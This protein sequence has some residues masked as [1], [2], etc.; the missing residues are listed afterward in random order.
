MLRW[1][2]YVFAAVLIALSAAVLYVANADLKGL[3]DEVESV[4][5]RSLGRELRIDGGFSL[6]LGRTV[7]IR[8]ADV[9][10]ENAPWADRSDMLEAGHV[11][12]DLELWSMFRGPI[13]VKNIEIHDAVF[14]LQEDAH[15]RHN[16]DPVGPGDDAERQTSNA[17]DSLSAIDRLAFRNTRI[18]I[19][20]P[21]L[22]DETQ[23]VVDAAEYGLRDSYVHVDVAARINNVPLR[24]DMDIGP[25][26][27]LATLR[28]LA[29]RGDA[30]LGEITASM[31][32]DIIDLG[33]MA[34]SSASIEI[35]GPDAAYLLNALNLPAVASGPMQM[36][37]SLVPD[38]DRSEFEVS[39]QFGEYRVAANGWLEDLW[40]EGGFDTRF[41]VSGPDLAVLGERLAIAGLPPAPFDASSRIL[42]G[43]NGISFDD[44]EVNIGETS[45]RGQGLFARLDDG[46][47]SL[48]VLV[49]YES[50]TAR[51]V[52]N[53]RNAR[54]TDNV[55]IDFDIEGPNA[56]EP[57]GEL[58][59]DLLPAQPF[60]ITGKA[61]Y[62]GQSLSLDEVRLHV[63][64]MGDLHGSVAL[65]N[66]DRPAFDVRL[67]SRSL[68][69]QT[70][71]ES[72]G[73]HAG[74]GVVDRLIPDF[75]IPFEYLAAFDANVDVALDALHSP[76]TAGAL[77][78]A[79]AQLR[80][81]RLD[82]FNLET[83]GKRGRVRASLV[84]EPAAASYDVIVDLA[85]QELYVAPPYEPEASLA[86]R[87]AY[88]LTASLKAHGNSVRDLADTLTGAV[89]ITAG[90]GKIPR[91]GGQFA[92]LFFEDFAS[93][94]LATIN[95]LIEERDSIELD[96]LVL[97]MDIDD[98]TIKG[99]PLLAL[100]T[101]ELN[102]LASGQIELHDESL[103]L[104]FAAQP[105][106]GL[107][108]SLGDLINPFTR[109]GGTLAA[110]QIV[111]DP[112]RGILETGAGV[113]TGGLWPLAKKL[114]ER[115]LGN[116]PC[117]RAL[118][119]KPI[120]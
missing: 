40:G 93:R 55:E 70:L 90:P 51:L 84:A 21:Y 1:L 114:R 23:I 17:T 34:V 106:R 35:D 33:S 65:S 6:R 37:A 66:R 57:A 26:G 16:W 119:T 92:T 101:R 36:A 99:D 86:A 58:R 103:R 46:R 113:A 28:E 3:K 64:G 27:N 111:A 104:D 14:H 115:F 76:L 60:R 79:Q 10:L 49:H 59:L 32:A 52:A 82:V 116:N 80:S 30:S 73:Q 5:G 102:L 83:N 2:V 9:V 54:A 89:Q 41:E 24:I 45:L 18:H 31:R 77:V 108:V 94:T 91:Q 22:T 87:P 25:T 85:G 110:P 47:M 75:R 96:C 42:S 11:A 48:D 88:E 68:T 109:V 43:P 112:K 53:T 120:R 67:R 74:A 78:R 7:R 71:G 63:S 61:A 95:P 105:R 19:V 81:G 39:G 117:N 29:I 38:P 97:K 8:A 44:A 100:Q 15:G 4:V 13:R 50:I 118:E 20:A 107:G 69:L 98:G 56:R 12:L 62:S 72:S